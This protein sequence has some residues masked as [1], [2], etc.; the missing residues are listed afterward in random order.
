MLILLCIL[1]VILFTDVGYSFGSETGF[2]SNVIDGYF[3]TYF[4]RAANISLKL[5]NEQYEET[6]IYTT[7]PWLVSLYLNCPSNF[8]LE[9]VKIQVGALRI[10]I[11]FSIRIPIL[12]CRQIF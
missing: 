3:H 5:R 12:W 6:F 10:S 11:K 7:H 1:V 2:I 8:I 9:G 4:S